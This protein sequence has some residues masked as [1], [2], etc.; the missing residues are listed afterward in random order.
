MQALAGVQLRSSGFFGT[1]L[2]TQRVAQRVQRCSFTV[3]AG[4]IVSGAPCTLLRCLPAP[5]PGRW[6]TASVP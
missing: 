4:R 6:V 2:P 5:L 3:Q 1:T